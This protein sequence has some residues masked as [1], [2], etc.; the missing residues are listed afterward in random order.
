MVKITSGPTSGMERW[1]EDEA[2]AR[3]IEL[4]YRPFA[5][6]QAFHASPAKYRLFGGAAGPGK[7]K[8]LLM[9]AILQANENPGANTL[10]LRRTF[11]ELEQSLLLY[12]RRDVPRELYQSYNESKHL[13]TWWNGSTTRF[14]YCQNEN[15][16]YQYQ[17]AEFLF[18]GIDELTLFTL[19]QWQFLTSRNRCPVP[20]AFPCMAGAT[21]PGNIGHAW[22][23]SLWIDKRP[24]PGMENPAEYDF[25]PA[26]VSD[27]PIY[28][29]DENYLKTLRALPSHLKRA[30]LDGDWDVFAGQYFDRFDLAQHLLRPEEVDWKPWWPRWI[31]IDWGFEHPAAVY[32]H[33][34]VPA[35][36][37]VCHSEAGLVLDG[38][39]ESTFHV[40]ETTNRRSLTDIRKQSG[41]VRD[42]TASSIGAG[43]P[44]ANAGPSCV[45]TYREYVT[46]RTPPRELARE[47]IA[48]SASSVDSTREKID[49]VYLSPDAFARRTDE[50]SI[51]EQMGDVFAAAGFPRPVPADDDRVGGWMLMY[52]ML[53]SGEWRLTENCIELIRTLPNLVRD[54][55][56][57]E[58]VEKMDG[59][60][61]ADAARYGLKSRYGARRGDP[62]GW[63]SRMPL[64]DRLAARVLSPDP[65]IGAMQAR[66]AQLE[67]MRRTQPVRFRRGRRH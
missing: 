14:G 15:D 32:W 55:A 31:S 41:W 34:A 12:F 62:G 30:F 28:A 56:R 63:R 38:A 19:R 39:E 61:P 40:E 49:A 9:E 5:K 6:Q 35:G 37:P 22:V 52:Q 59:D 47:I 66:K 21:N 67:E 50:A 44:S 10:L 46:H 33:A 24:A 11:P 54:P 3:Q 23:K 58:D 26:R 51:A 60:D 2:E 13:V 18:I 45:V 29:G 42:D 1:A 17:G 65:T 16:V 20:G 8:A 53:D 48:R 57:V 36:S 27:N 4:P 7:S 43:S 25:I 64:A